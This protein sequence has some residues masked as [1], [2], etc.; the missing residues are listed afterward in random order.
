MPEEQTTP[1]NA[2]ANDQSAA[3]KTAATAVKD[4][5][6]ARQAAG[7]E[8]ETSLWSGGYSPK[9]M[10]GT[11]IFG[12][13]LGLVVLIAAGIYFSGYFL[14]ALLAV[15]VIWAIT[16]GMYAYR[17]L[18]V[19]YEL[20]TQRFIH[21]SGILSRRTDRIEVIDI[22]DVSVK[23]GL[24]ERIFGVGSVVIQSSDTSH[25]TLELL[26]IAD[27]R[28]VA[29]LIDDIRRKERRRRSLHI[30]AI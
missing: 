28:N 8:V 20:T 16:A 13:V 19:H 14:W 6:K 12:A 17:R 2:D 4:E 18:G 9:A 10:V 26:G 1:P 21:Q 29:S 5:L 15:L 25:P 3:S 24:V 30:E 23:Q 11:W 22:D 27:V 7:D